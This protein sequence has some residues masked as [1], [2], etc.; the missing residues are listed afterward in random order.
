MVSR[1]DTCDSRGELSAAGLAPACQAAQPTAAMAA[2]GTDDRLAIGPRLSWRTQAGR[3]ARAAVEVLDADPADL[4][5]LA[6]SQ[7]TIDR[8]TSFF[9]VRV[10]PRAKEPISEQLPLSGSYR[11]TGDIIRFEPRFPLEPG[12][13]YQAQFDPVRLHEVVQTLARP[14][15]FAASQPRSR[16]RLI[17]EVA[18]RET[19][20]SLYASRQ[21]QS[22]AR[23][24]AGESPSFLYL[25]FSSDEPWGS[26]SADH[27][28]R[29]GNGE[30]GGPAVP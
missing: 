4:H 5:A 6:R 28:A 16:A 15:A 18:P 22:V 12:M 25:L 13:R 11:V 3:P 27:L 2:G 7:I 14:E 21:N 29:R 8:W 30:D 20:T 17:A 23:P 19:I 1:S 24:F 10:V 9:V 26:V